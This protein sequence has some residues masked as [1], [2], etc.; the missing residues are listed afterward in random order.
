MTTPPTEQPPFLTRFNLSFLATSLVALEFCALIFPALSERISRLGASLSPL[1]EFCYLQC[2]IVERRPAVAVVVL[3]SYYV[4]SIRLLGPKINAG[5]NTALQLY[6]GVL[7]FGLGMA[8][9][10]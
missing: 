6:M 3:L 10:A 5:V 9:R 2:S 7:L 8:V 4:L 1:S